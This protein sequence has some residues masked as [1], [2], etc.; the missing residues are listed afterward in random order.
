MISSIFISVFHGQRPNSR[1]QHTMMVLK[2]M[3]HRPPPTP[4]SVQGCKQQ[5]QVEATTTG[6]KT[7]WRP[8]AYCGCMSQKRLH[9]HYSGRVKEFCRPFCMSQYT[10]LFYGV[11]GAFPLPS[12]PPTTSQPASQPTNRTF[13]CTWP[14]LH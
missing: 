8:C 4:L 11:G 13:L 5:F 10:V 3:L 2:F 6:N 7:S 1:R 12:R 9:S 14:V